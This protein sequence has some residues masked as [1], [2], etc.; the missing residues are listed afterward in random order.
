[1]VFWMQNLRTS[2]PGSATA[3]A[4]RLMTNGNACGEKT[5]FFAGSSAQPLNTTTYQFEPPCPGL[6]RPSQAY[7]KSHNTM[8]NHYELL[9]KRLRLIGRVGLVVQIQ[10]PRPAALELA[11]PRA[12]HGLALRVRHDDVEEVQ[13]TDL[14]RAVLLHRDQV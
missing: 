13:G 12:A 9:R 14:L 8:E 2:A 11:L 1:M 6:A 5:A 3:R 7:N 10:E 4:N